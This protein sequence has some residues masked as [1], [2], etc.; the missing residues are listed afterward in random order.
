MS[1]VTKHQFLSTSSAGA[2]K[3]SEAPTPESLQDALFSQELDGLIQVQDPQMSS[4]GEALLSDADRLLTQDPKV[5]L[6]SG[7]EKPQPISKQVDDVQALLKEKKNILEK[8]DSQANNTKKDQSV[9]NLSKNGM[10]E[11]P[12]NIDQNSLTSILNPTKNI[13]QKSD[14]LSKVHV[15]E[16]TIESLLS[17]KENNALKLENAQMKEAF[18]K[19]NTL[20]KENMGS[21]LKMVQHKSASDEIEMR[22]FMK[23]LSSSKTGADHVQQLKGIE[24]MIGEHSSTYS[25]GPKLE[26]IKKKL[27]TEPLL[28]NQNHLKNNDANRTFVDSTSLSS[29]KGVLF[30]QGQS[31]HVVKGMDEVKELLIDMH[32]S[33]TNEMKVKVQH[34]DLGELLIRAT[35]SGESNL[36]LELVGNKLADLKL[37][38]NDLKSLVQKSGFDLNQFKVK[39]NDSA[40]LSHNHHRDESSSQQQNQQQGR[41]SQQGN[42]EQQKRQ[43]LW[44]NAKEHFQLNQEREA[45]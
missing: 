11:R 23:N 35:R 27:K 21:H 26:D 39:E 41:H 30:S 38:E 28:E 5:F 44:E 32:Q 15:K 19:D 2:K 34:Q 4:E 10:N 37:M 45:A 8:I 43:A 40:S 42:P 22:S 18:H 31:V 36:D 29:D 6:D 20:L 14:A 3:S 24:S 33:N 1:I 12:V 17:S 7:S 16:N 13:L 25:P 9:L